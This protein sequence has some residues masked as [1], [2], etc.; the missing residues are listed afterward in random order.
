M[1]PLQNQQQPPN[2]PRRPLEHADIQAAH[3]LLWMRFGHHAPHS[4]DHVLPSPSSDHQQRIPGATA[5]TRL[6]P[7]REHPATRLQEQTR[8]KDCIHVRTDWPSQPPGTSRR[9]HPP[10][11]L[12][13]LRP[14]APTTKPIHPGGPPSP[15]IARCKSRPVESPATTTRGE[16]K[17]PRP[18]DRHGPLVAVGGSVSMPVLVRKRDGLGRW[19][20]E[21]RRHGVV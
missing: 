6:P 14:R 12:P 9:N 13:L 10:S 21:V 20:R 3:L 5:A 18:G 4:E 8:T 2:R 19:A 17:P 11:C 16:T 7:A 1:K 15:S